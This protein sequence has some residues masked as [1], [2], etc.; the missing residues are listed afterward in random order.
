MAARSAAPFCTNAS[1][2]RS[3]A[4]WKR[5]RSAS[6]PSVSNTFIRTTHSSPLPTRSR[7]PHRRFAI[8][9]G[10]HRFACA[11]HGGVRAWGSVRLQPVAAAPPVNLR[12]GEEQELLRERFEELFANE[13][14]P[15]RVRA[16][17]PL[18]FDAGLW[19]QLVETGAAVMRVPEA[20]GGSGAGLLDAALVCELAG[21]HLASAPLVESIAASRLLSEVPGEPARGALAAVVA[22]T[23][24]ATLAVAPAW[25]G[26]SPLVPGG[27]V[28]DWVLGLEG[29]A[30]VLVRAERVGS[31]K[32]PPN[33]GSAPFARIPL[34]RSAPGA[35]VLL[36]GVAAAR[37]FEA[38]REEWKLL[39]AACVGGQ[40]RRALEIAAAYASE[41][42]QFGRPI[43][44]FQGV[45][46]PLAD[47]ITAV[48]GA[49]LLWL[50]AI[51][52]LSR[53]DP[54][55]AALFSMAFAFGAEAAVEAV[56]RSLH[57]HG[58]YGLSL[59]YD[60]QL[61]FR[62]GRASA[63]AGGSARADLQEVSRR[64]WDRADVA[65]PPPGEAAL[66]FGLGAEAEALRAEVRAFL[67]AKLTPELRA[68]AHFSWDGHDPGFQRELAAAG[69][70]YPHWPRE[71]G[72]RERSAYEA[73]AVEE[74]LLRVGWT[75]YAIATTGMLAETL[76]KFGSDEL[77]RDVLPRIARGEAVLSMGYTEPSAG[78]D[79]AAVSTR[80][81]RQ[82]DGDWV[83]DGQK[84]FTSG[85]H[86][87][88]YVFLLT[89][90]NQGAPKHRGL[91]LFLIPLD[92]PGI[93][94]QPVHTV[95]DERTNIT[96]YGGVRVPDRCRVGEVDGGWAVLAYALEIEHG[97]GFESYQRELV[98]AAVAWA[99][100]T[101]RGGRPVLEDPLARERLARSAIHAE[102][103]RLFKLRTLWI[104][105]EGLPD[106]GEGAM[107]KLFSSEQLAADARDLLD[108]AAPDSL[109]SRGAPGAAGDG[110]I[111][112]S[113]RHAAGTR[114]YAG[115]SEIMRS[116]IA[117]LALGM[118]RSRS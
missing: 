76:M 31:S 87:A 29:D 36:E 17:E 14:S 62:R 10:R 111:E 3:S 104:A 67:G 102:V 95:G 61:Y 40:A 98:E 99:R 21:R 5:S 11:G 26:A 20:R 96:Y 77:K 42:I 30:L 46:H 115:S 43:G 94:V 44:S 85:A 28:A 4:C 56:S 58:G 86:L 18:G 112:F 41:R 70:A 19:K 38:A 88:Q 68:R 105:A 74:E 114:I 79:V 33:L 13:S 75:N 69:L 117:Q 100:E 113:Y 109:L 78:S 37:A 65:L 32:P 72:G 48:D 107:T 60:I 12:F 23:A 63:L 47:A 53:G 2:A 8:D 50:E 116:V 64:L 90:T 57:V 7:M 25:D 34:S 73:Y 82:P 66:D 45:A 80:A 84:M 91:T 6:K 108:L 92:T 93:E 51:W 49:R 101:R 55:A 35:V 15:E 22:G 27:A 103:A 110:R 89:R 24:V 59:D 16:A 81:V 118:P 71:Y 54:R 106:R 1:V 39:T 83:V 9:P 52:A 97:T